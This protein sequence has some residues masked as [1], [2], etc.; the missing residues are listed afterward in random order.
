M[1]Q[2]GITLL[3][4]L[5]T[6]IL[7]SYTL[8]KKGAV[9]QVRL[10]SLIL[11]LLSLGLYFTFKVGF[12]LRISLPLWYVFFPIIIYNLF[13]KDTTMNINA[14]GLFI[15]MVILY[16]AAEEMVFR[17]IILYHTGLSYNACILNGLIFSLAHFVNYFSKVEKVS[18]VVVMVRFVLGTFLAM[19]VKMSGGSIFPPLFYHIL[20]N[21]SGFISLRH[22]SIR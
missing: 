22:Q 10:Q 6:L 17:G 7:T 15:P 1:Y 21:L 8:R 14:K 2:I 19:T 11:F 5:S 9:F 12:S 16:P 18:Y 4:Y 20:L 13:A 3:L